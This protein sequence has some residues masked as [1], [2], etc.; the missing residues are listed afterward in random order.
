M[1]EI[2]LTRGM[3]A[4]VD[5][6]DYDWLNQWK[7]YAAPNGNTFYAQR[8]SGRKETTRMHRLILGIDKTKLLC[9]HKDRNG[10]NNTRQNLRVA[11]KRE[12]SMNRTA[13]KDGSSKYLGVMFHSRDKVF[14]ASIRVDKKL[15]HLGLFSDEIEAAKA[16]N[17]AAAKYNGVFANLNKL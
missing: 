9:D 6:A 15:I 12:N 3:V 11:S 1:M 17:T 8:R 5:D 7:W 4:I 14:Y 16:Y 13:R 2:K 10:L